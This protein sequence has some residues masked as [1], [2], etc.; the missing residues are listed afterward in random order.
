VPFTLSVAV[1]EI[2]LNVSVEDTA[3][4]QVTDLAKEDFQILQDGVPQE[5]KYFG[6]EN[7]PISVVLLMDISGSMEG[8][9]LVEAKV[10]AL[11]FLN[12]S[13]PNDAVSLVAFND[14]VEVVRPFTSEMLKVR[15]GVH[16]L[17]S[18]GGL[19][20]TSDRSP[21]WQTQGPSRRS[22][23]RGVLRS[24]TCLASSTMPGCRYRSKAQTT[25]RSFC[26]C[27]RRCTA[28]VRSRTTFGL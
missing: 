10:A 4:R 17:T 18:R 27:G 23:S 3:G 9:P 20:L 24:G 15:T 2:L 26:R 6:H 16:S 21:R 8:S 1:E 7:V 28:G 12:E 22:I 25:D 19:D 5:I 13:R 11:A 14:K